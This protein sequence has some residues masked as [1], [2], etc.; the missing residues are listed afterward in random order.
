M[1]F[2]GPY[3]SSF[4]SMNSPHLCQSTYTPLKRLSQCNRGKWMKFIENTEPPAKRNTTKRKET[5][6]SPPDSFP[7]CLMVIPRAKH[8]WVSQVVPALQ[9][10]R[11]QKNTSP[12]GWTLVLGAV[13]LSRLVLKS[14][15]GQ[16]PEVW[17]RYKQCLL[18]QKMVYS[19]LQT[20][21]S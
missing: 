13:C 17:H 6:S 5:E 19:S 3:N 4:V 21:K 15:A 12:L 18:I 8:A 14:N 7:L 9:A 20:H 16:R 2:L 1:S 11:S 10:F